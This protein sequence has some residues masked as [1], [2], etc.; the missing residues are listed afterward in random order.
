MIKNNVFDT[1]AGLPVHPLIDHLVVVFIPVF[2]VALISV[3]FLP[4]LRKNYSL[5]TI[6]GLI[7][8]FIAAF[9]AKESGEALSLRVGTP[10]DHAEWGEKVVLISGLLLACSLVWFFV[11]KQKTVLA[12]LIGYLAAILAIAAIAITYLAGHSG[13]KATWEK[14]IQ[15]VT[16]SV[17]TSETTQPKDSGPI[18][19]SMATVETKNTPANCWAVVSNQ[20]YNLTA[21][22]NAHP[23]GA[24]NIT[25][26]CGTDAT[27]AF[28]N[29]HGSQGK[30][31]STLAAFVIGAL[32][33]TIESLPTQDSAA[34]VNSGEEE[35]NE[36]DED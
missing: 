5:I 35:E 24:A 17:V 6:I 14:R 18:E 25:N 26:L 10:S 33:S 23:G 30:P 36:G 7:I 22:I 4:R 1:I 2:S 28:A 9:V 19:L 27:K 21:Y 34:I 15:S 29:Q 12:K 16:E 31:N 8:S 32:G 11:N 20:V 13:A 3:I